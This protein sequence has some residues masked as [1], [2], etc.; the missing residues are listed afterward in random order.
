MS[1]QVGHAAL[2]QKNVFAY[3]IRVDNSDPFHPIVSYK[4][5]GTTSAV[6]VDALVN[7]EVVSTAPGTTKASNKVTMTI[8][9]NAAGIV[10]FKVT[11]TPK[12]TVT[13]PTIIKGVAI[14]DDKGNAIAG[15]AYGYRFSC[16]MSIS[17]NNAPNSPSFGQIVVA[18][19]NGSSGSTT[20]H[21]SSANG[22]RGSC[23][24]VFDPTFTGIQNSQANAY[25]F[26]AALNLSA[27]VFNQV[28]FSGDGRL[29]MATYKSN[30]ANT[31]GAVYEIPTA[32][33]TSASDANGFNNS[34]KQLFTIP[35]PTNPTTGNAAPG[36]DV[37]GS[38]SGLKLGVVKTIQVADGSPSQVSADF[39]NLG[40][41]TSWSGNPTKTI[42][43][44]SVPM[45][46]F[47]RQ[48]YMNGVWD[49]DGKGF[50]VIGRTGSGNSSGT[51][52]SLVH[53]NLTGT[54][55]ANYKDADPATKQFG[56]EVYSAQYNHDGTLLAVG[57]KNGLIEVYKVT[58]ATNGNVPT[59]TLACSFT[60]SGLVTTDVA[61]DYANNLYIGNRNNE[62]VTSYQLPAAIAGTSCTVPSP[63]SEAYEIE[64]EILITK[65]E[66][67]WDA[68]DPHIQ[69]LTV[70]WEDNNG[71]D[72]YNVYVYKGTELTDDVDPANDSPVTGTSTTVILPSSPYNEKNVDIVHRKVVI[73]SYKNGK[74]FK[75]SQPVA[76]E[77][78]AFTKPGTPVA[79]VIK[80]EDIGTV[81]I[82]LT[83]TAPKHCSARS[84]SVYRYP[85]TIAS[86][87]SEK[88]GSAVQVLAKA[89]L[90]TLEW[91]DE[92]VPDGNYQYAVCA[93]MQHA[94]YTS[95]GLTDSIQSSKTATLKSEVNYTKPVVV[96]IHTYSGRN[97]V[98]IDWNMN[99]GG[100][101]PTYYLLYRDGICVMPTGNFQT[102]IDEN[103]PDG[104]HEYQAVAVWLDAN[105]N[106]L[107]RRY[108]DIAVSDPV[109][110]E[111]GYEQ[112]GLDVIYNYR[113]YD[114]GSAAAEQAGSNCV[115]AK[116]GTIYEN[117]RTAVGA[118]GAPGDVFR[119]AVYQNHKWYIN[120][121]TDRPGKTHAEGGVHATWRSLPITLD[122]EDFNRKYNGWIV[123]IDADDPRD[124]ER[125]GED[126]L[127]IANKLVKMR[128]LMNQ[129]LALDEARQP[130]N[131]IHFFY[132][133][134]YKDENDPLAMPAT[135]SDCNSST[136]GY[137]YYLPMTGISVIRDP[138]EGSA[139][140]FESVFNLQDL[141]LLSK[142]N[143]VK[144]Q[145]FRTHYLAADGFCSTGNQG[146]RVF[147]AMNKEPEV[148]V[149]TVS[150]DND[151]TN[152]KDT[153]IFTM[154]DK[155]Q[156]V[157]GVEHEFHANT[158]NYA[159]PI[160]GRKDFIHQL[161]GS[162]YFYVNWESGTYTP[163][164]T[165]ST[166][167]STAGG[168]VF[169]FNGELFFINPTSE[170]SNDFG[171]F[172]IKMAPRAS[173]E[174]GVE[175]AT[176]DEYMI[177]VASYTQPSTG[178]N[179]EAG[180]SNCAW[181]GV[182]PSKTDGVSMYIYQYIP[183]I[184]FAKYRFYPYSA[185]PPVDPDIKVN[186]AH[187]D[188]DTDITHFKL[189]W[190]FIRPDGYNWNDG[191]DYELTDYA[192]R[193]YDTNYNILQEFTV[194]DRGYGADRVYSGCYEMDDAGHRHID[195]Q[196]YTIK[197]TPRYVYL[198]DQTREFTGEPTF[199]THKNK[200]EGSIGEIRTSAFVDEGGKTHERNYRIDIDFDR[201]DLTMYPEPVSY[202]TIERSMD[203]GTTW[204]E[205]PELWI[206]HQ[207]EVKNA[208]QH[209]QRVPGTY[210]FGNENNGGA[211]I[212]AV[213]SETGTDKGVLDSGNPAVAYYYTTDLSHV[214]DAQYR[215]VAHYAADN[216]YI[217]QHYATD[218]SPKILDVSPTGVT[219]IE[220]DGDV[221]YSLF[222]VPAQTT[223]TL[224]ADVAIEKVSIFTV[225]GALVKALEGNG[226]TTMTVNVSELPAGNYVVLVNETANLRLIKQ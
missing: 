138:H 24:Y 22:G 53:Y 15:A 212:Q 149:T 186:I 126:G 104:P 141:G 109:K 196:R 158:E 108:S 27:Y 14:K 203:D 90:T 43:A 217:S 215:A 48:L 191:Y 171:H 93:H 2:V 163:I 74:V 176:F 18:E 122:E 49:K 25:G 223:V 73:K 32:D 36:F 169:E 9:G 1:T 35:K 46:S 133:G 60:L 34:A 152:V 88:R 117:L 105:R 128:P 192:V 45:K 153:R 185:F 148:Y 195:N 123:E 174:A 100:I 209:Q 78:K 204:E 115:V 187:N 76:V 11:A 120:M 29:F 119:Q 62:Y 83:W 211:V 142:G 182:E 31:T 147:M 194:P 77:H 5:N 129:S 17:V 206:H 216:R 140:R 210:I 7:G 72:Y 38:G 159:F 193:L 67:A 37:V 106:E 111:P 172:R 51:D 107:A 116:P 214:T 150:I 69:N 4:L 87:G 198:E 177:P 102:F 91:T 84:Y 58:G 184:R 127:P 21:S 33:N 180:N 131:H 99:Y 19:A 175:T 121:L 224:K 110:R 52:M 94:I 151:V 221:T 61:F 190:S 113:I 161:R 144:D 68:K 95:S 63:E 55:T 136:V 202:F 173:N 79:E 10:T 165:H 162:G 145:H 118:Y 101:K 179:F 146:S 56:G 71:A 12:T 65:T 64:Q 226:D 155:Y 222:P 164:Y 208:D 135:V 199:A 181:F 178:V 8:P 197:V 143:T 137:A 26:S 13:K 44:T 154:P 6:T 54:P 157:N 166:N 82:K 89:K 40:T 66:A 125:R 213:N 50:C 98:N 132:K 3:D 47:I 167:C 59:F 30:S 130:E 124:P 218:A 41:A 207:G 156:D 28:R 189:D 97:S 23:L 219:E 200:Y 39:Y 103:V 20:Q 112:Y 168:L 205:I 160:P 220:T 75:V 201:A 57:K 188:D 70:E 42:A 170:T 183:G 139:G 114:D 16:P 85:I 92:M 80:N 225:N 81:D 96:E 134:Y 86:D